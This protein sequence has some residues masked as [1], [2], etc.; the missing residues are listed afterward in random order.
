METECH[1]FEQAFWILHL[2]HCAFVFT[3][4][5]CAGS[6]SPCDKHW[7]LLLKISLESWELGRSVIE[8]VGHCL[9]SLWPPLPSLSPLCSFPFLLFL[10]LLFFLRLSLLPLLRLS[11]PLLFRVCLLLARTVAGLP[12]MQYSKY[13]PGNLEHRF[14]LPKTNTWC[15]QDCS[16]VL[17][18][19]KRIFCAGMVVKIWTLNTQEGEAKIINSRLPWA[20]QWVQSQPRMCT[21]T[22]FQKKK[23]NIHFSYKYLLYFHCNQ[24]PP[25]SCW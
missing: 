18:F 16:W 14:L 23:K 11:F 5:P 2:T 10:F 15:F 24:E 20:P 9:C 3:P 19:Y 22:L 12:Q 6:P 21:E 8:T 17:P 25:D 1:C 13:P 7:I 4:A